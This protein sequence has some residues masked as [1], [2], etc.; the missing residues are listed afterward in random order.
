MLA[1]ALST[2]VSGESRAQG[3]GAATACAALTNDAARLACYDAAFAVNEPQGVAPRG[4]L[5]SASALGASTPPLGADRAPPEGQSR[6]GV[7]QPSVDPAEAQ[8][9]DNGQLHRNLKSSAGLPRQL[10]SRVRRAMAL[11]EGRYRLSLENGQ[12][13]QTIEADWATEFKTGD[14]VTISRLVL[15]GYDIASGPHGRGVRAKRTQ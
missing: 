12:V 15:G 1:L 4:T 10:T 6:A 14:T 5:Q 13:W 11:A 7:P 8:F 2:L 3:S 9:G